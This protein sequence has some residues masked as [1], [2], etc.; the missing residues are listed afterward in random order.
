MRFND[1]LFNILFNLEDDDLQADVIMTGDFDR[2]GAIS[3]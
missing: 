2:W 3:I 1:G